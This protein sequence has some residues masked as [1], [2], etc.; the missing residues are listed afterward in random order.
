MS[1]SRERQRDRNVL[2]LLHGDS[3]SQ[4]FNPQEFFITMMKVID[5]YMI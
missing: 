1:E 2:M 5:F 4:P 3:L